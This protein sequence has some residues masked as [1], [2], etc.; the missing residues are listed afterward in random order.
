MQMIKAYFFSNDKELRF[1]KTICA[2]YYQYWY[3]LGPRFVLQGKPNIVH[4]SWTAMHLVIELCKSGGFRSNIPHFWITVHMT[5]NTI[6]SM[7]TL[8]V[9]AHGETMKMKREK[10]RVYEMQRFQSNYWYVLVW[11]KNENNDLL[12]EDICESSLCLLSTSIF[13]TR[14]WG[15]YG[16]SESLLRF[17]FTNVH[18]VSPFDELFFSKTHVNTF[19]EY[20]ALVITCTCSTQLFVT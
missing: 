7:E 11:H 18:S 16:N 9:H 8:T 14:L 13:C 1:T 6:L 2:F 12:S 3:M 15:R 20:S 17:L 5:H 4:K 19:V 10:R